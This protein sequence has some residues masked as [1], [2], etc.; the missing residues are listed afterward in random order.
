MAEATY[1]AAY[2]LATT[3]AFQQQ[4]LISLYAALTTAMSSSDQTLKNTASNYIGQDLTAAGV[5]VGFRIA[6]S[7]PGLTPNDATV[8]AAVNALIPASGP[9]VL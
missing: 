5:R 2:T 7:M 1:G 9:F 4:V 6:D 8:Q 3:P